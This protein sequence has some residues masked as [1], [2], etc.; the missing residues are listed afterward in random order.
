MKFFF[1]DSQDL[2]DPSFD[3]DE[4]IRSPS[5][6][7]H[8]DDLYPHEVFDRPPYDGL[9]VSKAIVDGSGGSGGR[10]TLAQRH[11]FLREGV[12]D[13]FRLGDRTIETIG[14]CGA[15]SYARAEVPPYS[16]DEVIDFYDESRF[17]YGLSVDHIILGYRS[18]PEQG[19]AGMDLVPAEWRR[20]QAITIDLAAEFWSR[21]QARRCQFTP[22]GVAQGWSPD[23]Y[24]AAVEALQ[25]IGFRYIAFGGMVPLKTP[26]ILAVLEGCAPARHPD[27]RFHLLGVT[28]LG[29]VGRFGRM[30]VA[31]FDSTSPL[32]QAFK[33]DKDNYYTRQRTYPAVRVPQVE[34]NAKLWKRISS[35]QVGQEQARKCEQECLTLLRRYDAR[36]VAIEPV[37]E[38]LRAYELIHDGRVDRTQAYRSVLSDRPWDDCACALCRQVGIHVILFRGAERNRRRGFHNLYVFEERL[39]SGL[40]TGR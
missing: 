34:G 35:G 3:F 7:R 39:R 28:R 25:K 27:T 6:L 22:V 38:A 23:S 1:P 14:D 17:D 2:I 13:F 40:E 9:L 10:Y 16:V 5:R 20:R 32:R 33:D 8:R 15:F 26:E 37:L 30:G 24:R 36:D 19:L 29:H 4:E 31:S 11:R 21:H 18:G 12:R